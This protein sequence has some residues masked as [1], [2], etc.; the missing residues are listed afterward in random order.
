MVRS[1][2][3]QLLF[4][5]LHQWDCVVAKPYEGC[6]F[7]DSMEHKMRVLTFVMMATVGFLSMCSWLQGTRKS[8][9]VTIKESVFQAD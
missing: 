9:S 4:T 8:G 6:L 1:V 5:E 2:C 7:A 3:Q